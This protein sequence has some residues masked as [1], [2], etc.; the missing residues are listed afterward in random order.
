MSA[1]KLIEHI[2]C[3]AWLTT[4]VKHPCFG[5]VTLFAAASIFEALWSTTSSL[6]LHMNKYI[7]MRNRIKD[8]QLDTVEE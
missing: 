6:A 8:Q 2:I 3:A 7:Y 5:I 4:C 1:L